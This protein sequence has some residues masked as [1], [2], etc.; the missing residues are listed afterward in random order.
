MVVI[1]GGG[2]SGVLATLLAAPRRQLS[3]IRSR[4]KRPDSPVMDA[5]GDPVE[6]NIASRVPPA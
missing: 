3:S 1:S 5:A 4:A 2:A 6:E